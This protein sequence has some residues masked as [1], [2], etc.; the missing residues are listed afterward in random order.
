VK[1]SEILAQ[2]YG[3]F[4]SMPFR[5]GFAAIRL[6]GVG[7]SKYRGDEEKGLD[8]VNTNDPDVCG[9]CSLGA[10]LRVQNVA[11]GVGLNDNL[12]G[13]RFLEKAANSV[14]GYHSVA[15]INDKFPKLVDAMWEK[16][17]QLAKEAEGSCALS[18]ASSPKEDQ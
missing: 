3:L 18:A 4:K 8:F 12:L 15:T 7:L 9:V 6:E 13:L 14:G 1:E 5:G 2:A 10:L 11:Q 17:I 16:A